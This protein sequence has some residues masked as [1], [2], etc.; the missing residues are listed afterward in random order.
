M[1]LGLCHHAISQ[2]LCSPMQIRCS[3]YVRIIEVICA[4]I[5]IFAF[6]MTIFLLGRDVYLPNA[7]KMIWF[8]NLKK[9][10]TVS[11]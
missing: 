3:H 4:F 6:I 5:M 10:H 7:N 11:Q 2:H 9:I 8:P 1:H